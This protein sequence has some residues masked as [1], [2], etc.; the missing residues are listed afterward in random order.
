MY[1]HSPRG[2]RLLETPPV[3]EDTT[4]AE[5][6]GGVKRT[7]ITSSLGEATHVHKII[8]N[9]T[10]MSYTCQIYH[11]VFRTRRS[12]PA[13]TQEYREDLF[14][15]IW[16]IIRGQ[17]C[18]LYQINCM[19]D[20]IHMLI[21]L[22]PSLSLSRFVQ[23]VKTSSNKFLHTNK[24]KFPHF[25]SW[26]KEYF[27]ST[28]SYHDKEKIIRYIRNQQEHHKKV[29]LRDELITLLRESNV[30]YNEKYIWQV[31]CCSSY[32]RNVCPEPQSD[33][34]VRSWQQ[35]ERHHRECI[36]TAPEGRDC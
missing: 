19:P 26:G 12:V 31:T 29:S 21:E 14:R 17:K 24:D 5:W 34:T 27:A 9:T 25:E 10:F 30:E 1:T 6:E 8:Q 35:A 13:L 16:G 22:H 32:M 36:P 3:N 23:E 18:K 15:F 33:A 11:I 4:V 20:H 7:I 28:Y 2:A